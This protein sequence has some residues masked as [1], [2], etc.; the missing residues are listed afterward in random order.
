MV[1]SIIAGL[2]HSVAPDGKRFPVDKAAQGASPPLTLV[3]NW[4]KD[5]KK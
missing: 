5:P 4:A 3:T 1:V 2:G